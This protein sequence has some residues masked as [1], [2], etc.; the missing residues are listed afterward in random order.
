VDAELRQ[1]IA[2][3]ERRASVNEKEGRTL[4]S[5]RSRAIAAALRAIDV[6]MKSFDGFARKLRGD[7]PQ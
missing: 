5:A 2:D 1:H 3:M 7:H 6:E 4:A